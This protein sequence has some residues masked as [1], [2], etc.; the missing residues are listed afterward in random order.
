MSTRPSDLTAAHFAGIA[1]T[2]LNIAREVE[3]G[4]AYSN[5]YKRSAG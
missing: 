1:D 3:A 4:I 5:E 2:C